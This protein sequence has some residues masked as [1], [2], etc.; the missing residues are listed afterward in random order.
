MTRTHLNAG[1]YTRAHRNKTFYNSKTKIFVL[2][3]KIQAFTS[4]F[5]SISKRFTLP[6]MTQ[7]LRFPADGVSIHQVNEELMT[8]VSHTKAVT[9]I[10]KVKGLVHLIM[11]RPPDQNPNTYLSY[12]PINSDKCNGNSDDIG[13][14]TK[15]CSPP[16]E[17]SSP[18]DIPPIGTLLLF[19]PTDLYVEK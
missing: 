1:L 3:G 2:I 14:K 17:N 12:L 16:D 7:L 8:G 19:I 13:V 10:R 18:P 9:T 11:S 4:L 15:P 5:H 6:Y